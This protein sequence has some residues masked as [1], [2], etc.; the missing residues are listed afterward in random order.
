MFFEVACSILNEC[1]SNS[2][3]VVTDEFYNPSRP[4]PDSPALT[5]ARLRVDDGDDVFRGTTRHP[6]VSLNG[7]RATFPGHPFAVINYSV[8]Q[9]T[10]TRRLP[11]QS[12]DVLQHPS[13]SRSRQDP[14]MPPQYPRGVP[15]YSTPNQS[16]YLPPLSSSSRN[17]FESQEVTPVARYPSHSLPYDSRYTLHNQHLSMS[18]YHPSDYR[19]IDELRTPTSYRQPESSYASHSQAHHLP[20]E[21]SLSGSKYECNYCGKG[22]NRPSSL[23]ARPCCVTP[24]GRETFPVSGGRLW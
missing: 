11:S 7:V 12:S 20:P 13:L 23:K 1:L 22:F 15:A 6:A 2:T 8:L 18:S 16:G 24:Y 17:Q 10:D 5:L 9:R 14:S 21:Q 4:H 19:H 3:F